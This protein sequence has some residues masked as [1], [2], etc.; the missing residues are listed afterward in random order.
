MTISE[1]AELIR[2]ED[3]TE[4]LIEELSGDP[5]AGVRR[6]LNAY[7]RRIEKDNKER[8]RVES[9]YEPESRFYREGIR[10]IAGIDEVGRGPLAGPVTVA[11][12]ILPAHWFAAGLNDSKQVTPAHREMLAEKIQGAAVACSVVSLSSEEVD[13]LNIYNATMTAMY[14]AVQQ[15]PVPPEAVIVDAMPLHFKVPVL[16]MIHG[17]AR[18]ASVA[19]A[20]IV[21]KVTR[22]RMMKEYD[23][24]YPGYGFAK[25]KGYG[26]AEH[27]EA[28]R[29]LGITPIHRRS[30]EPVRSMTGAGYRN[31][32]D[33]RERERK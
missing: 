27:L 10:Y 26:T 19:A 32:A 24:V 12:V 2:R 7:F 28:I 9:M 20:S 29:R 6:I 31:P 23:S 33:D 22:D 13:R 18:S 25:H 11:A 5:R 8:L 14:K 17:D 1:I 3:L 15:L 21:A 16:S 30:F 4:E